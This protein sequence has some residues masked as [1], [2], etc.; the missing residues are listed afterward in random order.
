MERNKVSS[1]SPFPFPFPSLFHSFSLFLSSSVSLPL[2][3][4]SSVFSVNLSHVTLTMLS[5]ES[6]HVDTEL[7]VQT[8]CLIHNEI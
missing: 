6:V 7:N 1:P 8:T 4:P 3:P 5:A 2:F